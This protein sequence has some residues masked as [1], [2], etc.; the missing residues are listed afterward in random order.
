MTQAFVDT[1]VIVRLLTGD[2]PVKQA[3]ARQLFESVERGEVELRSPMTVIADAVYVLGS[4]SLYKVSRPDIR[5]M[6]T[7]LVRL[8]GYVVDSKQVVIRS[9]AIY[10]STNL[11]FGDAMLIA[12]CRQTRIPTLYSYDRDY[13]QFD[14]IK[15]L[16]PVA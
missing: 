2:D 15:R 13:D 3:G 1:D 6:L 11:D 9:L 16:E 4:P 5:D 10:G 8:S 14:E 12:A 7:S